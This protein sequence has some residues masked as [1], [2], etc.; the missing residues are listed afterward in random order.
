MQGQLDPIQL[1]QKIGELESKIDALRT[2]EIGGVWQNYTV[3]WTASS[4]NPSI[5]NGSLVSRYC[6]IGKICFFNI[7]LVAGSTTTF[8]AGECMFSLPFTA[9][10][11]IGAGSVKIFDYGTAWLNSICKFVSPT[12]VYIPPVS[13][14]YPMTWTTD[15]ILELSM[16][17]EIT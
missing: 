3:V 7:Y 12:Q 1:M 6:V 8:G 9:A 5:G 2:I 4:T 15:D 11:A 16:F 17:Y 10:F 13:A 14:T